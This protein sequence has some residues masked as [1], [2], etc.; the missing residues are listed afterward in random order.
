MADIVNNNRSERPPNPKSFVVERKN[1]GNFF[2]RLVRSATENV[3]PQP[4]T[5]LQMTSV[6]N[7]L[8][9]RTRQRM[10]ASE[11]AY[12]DR[13]NG[14]LRSSA[15]ESITKLVKGFTNFYKA[16]PPGMKLVFMCF[17]VFMIFIMLPAL[18]G[19]G[20]TIMESL[21]ETIRF[22]TIIAT[23]VVMAIVWVLVSF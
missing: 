7:Q 6:T 10:D 13:H 18:L 15:Q 22:V 16:L 9:V 19:A 12:I 23:M 1:H 5:Y 8:D 21:T 20:I 3:L 17:V 14:I 2:T 11:A 4:E